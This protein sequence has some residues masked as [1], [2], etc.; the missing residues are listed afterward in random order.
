MRRGFPLGLSR[1]KVLALGAIQSVAGVFGETVDL[2]RVGG[3]AFGGAVVLARG[4]ATAFALIAASVGFLGGRGLGAALRTGPR[5]GCSMGH[6]RHLRCAVGASTVPV[7]R[8][9][10]VARRGVQP[11]LAMSEAAGTP[12]AFE[13]L[14]TQGVAAARSPQMRR[15]YPPG[16]TDSLTS[17]RFARA[18]ARGR[19]GCSEAQ[20]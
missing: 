3:E 18:R 11:D 5:A 7:P 1:S 19:A 4:R 8:T 13:R 14:S 6:R 20:P 17:A 10:R 9:A 12:P 15:S 16:S 2:L